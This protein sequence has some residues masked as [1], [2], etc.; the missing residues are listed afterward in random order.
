MALALALMWG[1]QMNAQTHNSLYTEPCKVSTKAVSQVVK[2][3]VVSYKCNTLFD[4]KTGI[5]STDKDLQIGSLRNGDYYTWALDVETAGTYTFSFEAADNAGHAMSVY[6]ASTT[7]IASTDKDVE[8]KHVCDGTMPNTGGYGT[9]SDYNLSFD[10]PLSK[11]LNYLR[12]VWSGDGYCGNLYQMQIQSPLICKFTWST[13]EGT[14]N[15]DEQKYSDGS[16]YTYRR[17]ATSNPLFKLL[18]TDKVYSD[19]RF[20]ISTGKEYA[21]IVPSNVKVNKLVFKNC[22]EN[23]YIDTENRDS[24]WDYIKSGVENA[25]ISNDGKI[26]KKQDITATFT[27]HQAGAPI[28]FCVKKCAQVAYDAIEIQGVIDET[29]ETYTLSV[30]DA[31][32]ATLVLPFEAEMPDGLKAYKLTAVNGNKITTEELTGKVPANTPVLVNAAKG[33]YTFASTEMAAMDIVPQSGLLTGVWNAEAVSQ[34]NYVLQMQNGTV[35]FYPVKSDDINLKARQAYLTL[36]SD[37]VAAN[38]LTIDFGTETGISQVNT[39]SKGETGVIYNA[40]GKRVANMS[41]PGL[42]IKNGKKY[43]IK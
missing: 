6:Q 8:Y 15:A 39:A 43:I 21:V 5:A 37:A 33:E 19:S 24:E 3:N 30:S 13:G 36:P 35:A 20:K 17:V 10:V 9:P 11:G 27:N 1:T 40:V 32:A 28:L 34:N 16:K 2:G 12:I 31:G 41:Q 23:Y 29:A 22:C 42:Y 4:G 26:E 18:G 25:V 14:T 38:K 7:S